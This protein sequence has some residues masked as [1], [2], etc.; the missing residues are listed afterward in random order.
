MRVY[1][2][3]TKSMIYHNPITISGLP[4]HLYHRTIS[5]GINI[6]TQ[7]CREVHTCMEFCSSVN[8]VDTRSVT[9]SC[10]AKVFI[11][12]RLDSGD[13]TQH[14]VMALTHIHHIIEGTR[15]DIELLAEHIH[16]LSCI[17][18]QIG[19][20]HIHQVFITVSAAIPCLTNSRR[21]RVSRKYNPIQ[22][23]ITLLHILQHSH[24][25]VQT[26]GKHIIL[27]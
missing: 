5:C 8:R 2:L 3:I 27:R 26:T 16:L 24:C 10:F 20:R 22:V 7:R 15:L 19:V 17:H 18:Y 12:N 21:Y 23:I 4:P 14:F 11:G 1:G 6:R 13:T 9:G 25:L